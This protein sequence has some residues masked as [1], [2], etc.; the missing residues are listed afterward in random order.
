MSRRA[1]Y[2]QT[3]AFLLVLVALVIGVDARHRISK[4]AN[5]ARRS[6]DVQCQRTRAFSPYIGAYLRAHNVFPP[7]VYAEYI[8]T[9]PKDC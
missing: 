1:L 3:F 4:V 2:W 5:D 8:S 9:I 7:G 6:A